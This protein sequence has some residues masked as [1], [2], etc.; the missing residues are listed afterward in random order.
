MRKTRERGGGG[1]FQ[2]FHLKAVGDITKARAIIIK[3]KRMKEV[4]ERLKRD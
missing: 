4:F 3:K 2:H 1:V